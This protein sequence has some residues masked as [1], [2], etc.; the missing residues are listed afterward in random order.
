MDAEILTIYCLCDDL[1]TAVGHKDHPQS[2]MS[3]AEVMTVALVAVLHFG[4]NFAKARRWLTSDQWIPVMLGKS[5]YSRRL[6]RVS[7]HF[8]TLFEIIAET[9]KAMNSDQVYLI[10]TF[11]IPV[12]D[13]IRITR[14]HIYPKGSEVNYHGYKSSKRRYFYGLKLHLLVTEQG[15]PVEFLLSPGA[16]SDVSG[17]YGFDFDLPEGASVIGDAA[18]TVYWLEDV[19]EEAGLHLWPVRKKNS[20]RLHES[21]VIGLQRLCRQRVE[22]AGS[23]IERMLPKSIHATNAKG[24]ELKV[25][26]FVLGLSIDRLLK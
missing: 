8:I 26:L 20:T 13:N 3:S 22:T 10:D 21:W 23:L 11:P 1:L 6:H 4:G 2:R 18:Y 19:M 24:F 5:R 17:V 14:C 15:Y 12:C 9:W 7:H 16:V 25:I